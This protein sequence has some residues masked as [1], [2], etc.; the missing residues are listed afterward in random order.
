MAGV[1]VTPAPK[2]ILH[3]FSVGRFIIAPLVAVEGAMVFIFGAVVV[4]TT[5][6]PGGPLQTEVNPEGAPGIS[7][8]ISIATDSKIDIV[9]CR[10][11]IAS[12]LGAKC[13]KKYGTKFIFD[14]RGFLADERIEGGIWKKA[15][16]HDPGCAPI[17]ARINRVRF[18]LSG[19]VNPQ[20]VF[21]GL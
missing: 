18:C 19:V 7:P 11:Y 6:V 8:P 1:K 3:K 9:H 2:P 10:G 20:S 16:A 5:A 13:K 12:L 14:M 15:E 21:I 4:Y 17:N